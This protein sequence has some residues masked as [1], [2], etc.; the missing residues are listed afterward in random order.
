MSAVRVLLVREI[1][2]QMSSSG[3]C[4][5]VAGDAARW[6]REGPVFAERRRWMEE[7]GRLYRGLESRFGEKVQLDVV[8]PRNLFSYTALLW[9]AGRQAGRSPLPLMAGWLTGWHRLAVFVDGKPIATGHVPSL[10][11]VAEAVEHRLQ[12]G[13]KR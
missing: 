6:S 3:C 7:M 2:G 9:Q 5:R 8:D 4:G 13:A 1:D 11:K 10:E 12:F